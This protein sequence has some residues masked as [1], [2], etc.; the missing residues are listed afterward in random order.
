MFHPQEN[1]AAQQASPV[2]NPE[3][4]GLC[5]GDDEDVKEIVCDLTKS[6]VVEEV[7]CT[8]AQNDTFL[9]SYTGGTNL[10]NQTVSNSM[11]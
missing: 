6:S 9:R 4:R 2:E 11:M 1:A 7:F 8:P 10:D 3:D 5:S